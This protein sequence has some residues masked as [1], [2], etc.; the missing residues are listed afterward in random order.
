MT[1]TEILNS[2]KE[3]IINEYKLGSTCKE[4]ANKYGCDQVWIWKWLK[5]N[6]VQLRKLGEHKRLKESIKNGYKM[7]P[8]DDEYPK[9]YTNGGRMY[10]EHIIKVEKRLGRFLAGNEVVHHINLNRLDNNDSNLIE[11]SSKKEHA[12][13]HNQLNF[14]VSELI[15]KN[16]IQ[17]NFLT[18]EYQCQK[19][20]NN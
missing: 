16:I 19:I 15:N 13:I 3:T 6:N 9:R 14:L 2:N 10:Y 1:K 5:K 7:I 20:E 8:V 12:K 4:L 17:F 11:C 18:K